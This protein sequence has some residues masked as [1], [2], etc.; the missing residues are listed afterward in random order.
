M[1]GWMNEGWMEEWAE[2]GMNG[3]MAGLTGDRWMDVLMG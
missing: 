3:W 1:D 2:E